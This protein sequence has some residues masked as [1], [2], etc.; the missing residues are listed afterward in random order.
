MQL[1]MGVVNPVKSTYRPSREKLD[2]SWGA[3]DWG[4]LGWEQL[5]L[6]ECGRGRMKRCFQTNE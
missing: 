3:A 2:P 1:L 6:A 4:V 5:V